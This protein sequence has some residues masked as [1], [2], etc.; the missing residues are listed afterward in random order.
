MVMTMI[1]ITTMTMTMT[2]MIMMTM[3][4]T[5]TMMTIMKM[6]KKNKVLSFVR[7]YSYF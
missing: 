1:V 5:M 4:I 7:R 3:A 2:M 6:I